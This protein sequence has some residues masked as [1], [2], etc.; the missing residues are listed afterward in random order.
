MGRR[1]SSSSVGTN[2]NTPIKMEMNEHTW[3]RTIRSSGNDKLDHGSLQSISAYFDDAMLNDDKEH[4]SCIT[5]TRLDLASGTLSIGGS[6]EVVEKWVKQT[7]DG[8]VA[9]YGATVV[10][11]IAGRPRRSRVSLRIINTGPMNS[12]TVFR[13]LSR[14]NKHMD[15]SSWSLLNDVG[16]DNKD[17]YLLI[18]FL[19]D[20]D[21]LKNAMME[22][23][24]FYLKFGISAKTEVRKV[25][26]GNT[27]V[28]Y[29]VSQEKRLKST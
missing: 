12:E 19:C 1:R 20:L 21:S 14:Y 3:C 15:F 2:K 13:K 7:L 25:G 26:G 28:G 11:N 6:N 18:F 22:N 16:R 9:K 4:D 27:G 5:D 24:K 10:K 17:G 23:G 29:C 8:V